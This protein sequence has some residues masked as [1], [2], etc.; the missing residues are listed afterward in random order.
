M[1]I[2]RS[3]INHIHTLSPPGRFLEKDDMT[4]KWRECDIKR[5]HEKTAQALR[6]GAALLRASKRSISDETILAQSSTTAKAKKQRKNNIVSSVIDD[7]SS[8]KPIPPIPPIPNNLSTSSLSEVGLEAFRQHNTPFP[9]YYTQSQA[10]AI[11]LASMK[12]SAQQ[13]GYNH[14]S[15]MTGKPDDS[16]F[17]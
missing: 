5:A 11:L 1:K 13:T 3:I 6:D 4:G 8:M 7:D 15:S 10:S 17:R 12:D 16:N 9:T 14:L 2:T